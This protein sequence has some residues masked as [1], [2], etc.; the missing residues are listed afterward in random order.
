MEISKV[1]FGR[2]FMSKPK[3]SSELKLQI[4]KEYLNGGGSY[5]SLATAFGV[6]RKSVE[7]WIRTYRVQGELAFIARPN[8]T[9]YS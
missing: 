7:Q 3:Y 2:Y 4:V 9:H 6:G 1:Y 8:N 5:K